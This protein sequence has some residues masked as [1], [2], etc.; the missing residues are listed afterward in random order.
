MTERDLIALPCK[1]SR[2]VFP[3]ERSF[4]VELANGDC[5]TGL[6]P[7]HFCWNA[8]GKLL[9]DKEAATDGEVD[10]FVAARFAYEIDPSQQAVEVPD[11]KVI[12]V[13][14]ESIRRRPTPIVPPRGD[15]V[16]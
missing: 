11:G 14:T 15:N 6:S 9:G 10:G 12:A 13:R 16:A 2:G 8:G 7:R 4:E 1:L 5:Y 3:S